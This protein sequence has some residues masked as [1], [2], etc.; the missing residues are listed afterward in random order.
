MLVDGQGNFGSVDGDPP[1]AMR[2][3][4][5]RM[6]RI[7]HELLADL[8]KD[9]VDFSPNYDD[10]EK[11]PVV[12]PTL[13]PNLLINGSSGI[14]VG[15]AT[16]IPPHNLNEVINATLALIEDP[17]LDNE[18]L[19]EHLPGPDFPTAALICG[20][21]GIRQAYCT[22]R[23][24]VVMRARCH[25]ETDERHNKDK[26]I[27]TELPY[28]VNKARLLEKIAE[29][30]KE[31]RIDSISELRDESDKDGIRVVIEL[32]RHESGD[33]LLN[34]LYQDTQLQSAFSVN[35][36]VLDEGKPILADLKHVLNAFLRHRREVVTRRSLFELYKAREKAHILEGQAVALVNI[37][38]VI[39]LIKASSS[40]AEAKQGLVEKVWNP[41]AVIDMLKRAKKEGGQSS[42]E[43]TRP[44]NLEAS[45][46]LHNDGYHLSPVQAQAILDL[47]LHRLT[48]LEQDKIASDYKELVTE[49][50]RL[51]EILSDPD[52]LMQVICNELNEIKDKFGDERRSEI[53]ADE[54]NLSTEDLI[55]EKDVAVTFSHEGYVKR[56]DMDSYKAQRRGGKGKAAT[57]V[58]EEDFVE[59]LFIASTHDT[60]LCFSNH[61]KVHWLKVHQLPQAGRTAR[62]KPI[63]NVL[64]LAKGERITVI[65]PLREYLP[66]QYVVMATI[67]GKVK[68]TSVSNF[69]KPRNGGIRAISLAEGDELAGVELTQGNHDVMLFSDHGKVVRFNETDVQS[70]SR[71]AKGVRGIRLAEKSKVMSLITF[72]PDAVCGDIL[73]VTENGYGKRTSAKEFMAKARGGKGVISIQ[74]NER[75]GNV[76]GAIMVADQNEIMLIN[77]GGTLIRMKVS[78]IS[79]VG[80]NTVGVRLIRLDIDKGDRLVE[81]EEVPPIVEE[82]ELQVEDLSE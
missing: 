60:L 16:N 23:G 80:R 14:A 42:Q 37:D 15:M 72:D 56:Q 41:G 29:L 13:V 38:E 34:N 6:S 77:T 65:L 48:A 47:R 45:Y 70:R 52:Q 40:P 51:I 2:Y 28:L 54:L 63:V 76:V 81:V 43:I 58:K 21:E 68:R 10:S 82:D 26:I 19:I 69:S 7:A 18:A 57:A 74:T 1:A 3:T 66:D 39:A 22:G 24:R 32:K 49:I 17:E 61:G 4:E 5:I 50:V 55:L 36:V 59:K 67:R 78:D 53:L 62:G 30:I 75:N 73:V 33:V 35:M 27:V 8:D 71:A 9:T 25:V 79:R 12:L 64:P 46:G 20:R 44:D 31:K 11:E